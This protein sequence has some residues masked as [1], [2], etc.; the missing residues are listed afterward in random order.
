MDAA[1]RTEGASRAASLSFEVFYRS[2]A[3]R[4]RRTLSAILGDVE[5]AGEAT[6]EAMARAFERWSRVSLF[7]NPAGWVYRVGLNWAKRQMRRR[8]Y[9]IGAHA[10]LGISDELSPPDPHLW[11]A[12]SGLSTDHRTVVILRFAEDWSE[13]QIADALGVPVGTVKSRL[14]RALKHLREELA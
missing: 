1:A 8:S 7:D 13:S 12:L 14:H 10:K 3:G 6:D 2:N 11:K 5:L 9:D 4:V